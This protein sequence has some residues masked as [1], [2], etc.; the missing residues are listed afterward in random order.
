MKTIRDFADQLT[1]KRVLMRVDFNVPL[2]KATGAITNDLRIRMALPTIKFARERRAKVILMSH[3][4]RPKDNKPDPKLSLKKVAD[5]LGELLGAKVQFASDCIGPEAEKAAKAL[6]GGEV[7]MLE[8]TRFHAGDEANDPE[9]SRQLASL[10]DVFINDAFG[11]A[12][13]A[14]ASTVGVAKLLPSAAGFLIEKEVSYLSRATT[15][16]EHPYVAVMGG[17]KVSDKINVLRNLLGKVDSM[18][19]GG[20][21]AYT[22]LKQKG[23][24]VGNSLVEADRLDVARELMALGGAKIVLPVDHVCAQKIDAAAEVKTFKDEIPDGWIGLDIGPQTVALFQ[25]KIKGAALVTWN[26][27]LGYFE[28]EEFAAGTKAIASAMAASG[29]TTIVGGGETAEAVEKLGLADK[30]SHVSTGGGASLEFL[31]GDKLPGIAAL[32]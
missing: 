27:P 13:R 28:I 17:A 7:L 5:R 23:V 12:H 31:A 14:H 20:A 30:I 25:K 24:K 19:I 26:G 18:L 32:E 11:T 4:G 2:D 16:P 10:A 9:M 6:K 1:G 8:N 21:M 22:F 29:A 3:L 15:N